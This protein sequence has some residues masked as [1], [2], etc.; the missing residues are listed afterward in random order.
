MANQRL[1]PHIVIIMFDVC[2][3][4]VWRKI[5]AAQMVLL[6]SIYIF[7]CYCCV[8]E[9]IPANTNC[10]KQSVVLLGGIGTLISV[11]N[12]KKIEKETIPTTR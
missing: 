5:K 3:V 2:L 7:F 12:R 6:I 1:L 9:K 8:G 10:N 11:K 4:Y